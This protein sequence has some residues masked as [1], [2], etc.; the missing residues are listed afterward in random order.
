MATENRGYAYDSAGNLHYRTN[1]GVL[2]TFAVDTKNELTNAPSP[3]SALTY[4]SNG[5]I[6]T[7]QSGH[8]TYT[9]DD[10]NRLIQWAHYQISPSNPTGGDVLTAFAYD[11]LG[12]LRQRAEYVCTTIQQL[13]LPSPGTNWQLVTAT[14][15]IYDGLRVIQE[16]DVNNVPVVSYT[17]GTDLGGSLERAGGIGGLLA[18]SSGYSSGNWSTHNFYH[19]DGNGNITY[20]QTSAQGL[21]ASYR[22]DPFGNTIS[23]SGTLTAANVYRFSSKEYMTNSGTYYYLLR[24]YDPTLQRWV[25]RDPLQEQGGINLYVLLRNA[26]CNSVD[27]FGLAPAGTPTDPT[28][29]NT[30]NWY[31]NV[32]RI[33]LNLFTPDD[34]TQN[35][36]EEPPDEPPQTS[37]S[38]SPQSGS[39]QST[40]SPP[41]YQ[42]P[43]Q[44][45]FPT[46]PPNSLPIPKPPANLLP[47]CWDIL[48]STWDIFPS[49]ISL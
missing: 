30:W 39:G 44:V 34:P 25:N 8:N 11:G 28:D 49:N 41:V 29:P 31:F 32:L 17:R 15:Y 48:P 27:P 21:A 43:R 2:G 45:P 40:N 6:A 7:A 20:L 3:A 47:S 46:P 12:R 16:R 10:E 24:L 38:G 13:Q 37:Q 5:N 33:I 4:D 18:R 19:A 9:Y 23:S 22:Y 1:D 14:A 35:P 26:P 36:D 42:Y